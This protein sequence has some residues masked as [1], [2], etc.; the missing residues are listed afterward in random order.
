[1]AENAGHMRVPAAAFKFEDFAIDHPGLAIASKSGSRVGGQDHPGP[2]GKPQ[3]GGQD[4]PWVVMRRGAPPG[5]DLPLLQAA[6]F[7]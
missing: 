3:E 7:V 4:H 5:S 6:P 1:M 2:A